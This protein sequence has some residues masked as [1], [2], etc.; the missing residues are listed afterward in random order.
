MRFPEFEDEWKTEKIINILTI[1]SGR[2]YKH[3][4]E[5][6][7]PVYGT[8]GHMTSVNNFLYDG[9]SV[10]IGRKGTI[11]KPLYL[12]GKFWTVDTLFYTHSFINVLPKFVYNIFQQIN[13]LKYNEASGVPSLSK[14]TIEQIDVN[15]PTLSEQLKITDF[16]SIINER[17]QTQNKILLHYQS[18]IKNLR[19]D[20]FKQ[21]LKL[22]DDNQVEFPD[23]K[24]KKLSTI[25][26]KRIS[27][28]KKMDIET[29]LSNSASFGIINQSDFF[30]KEITNQN[31]INS[32]YVVEKDDFVYNPRISKEAPVGPISRN[33]IGMGVISP[34]YMVFRFKE[35]YV[36]FFEHFFNSGAWYNHIK[37]IA[38]YGARADRISF[39][40]S[41]FFEMSIPFP[42]MKEQKRIASFLSKI[43]QIIQIEKSILEQLEE[44]KKYLLQQM[45]V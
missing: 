24:T 23:W 30:D 32:Y 3:L 6:N 33:K 7:I 40:N 34:L 1:G 21:Y 35:G 13:W 8:G 18:L 36:D 2:D 45:F 5:G 41:A 29:V 19:K 11:N 43:D 44:Q 10:C 31:N 27:K 14:S 4:P 16:L 17:I 42:I 39:S 22:K 38:N 28:N 12:T 9:E 20:I 26:G 25:A 15:I 37:S